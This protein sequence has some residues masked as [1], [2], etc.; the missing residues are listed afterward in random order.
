V[1][2]DDDTA[3]PIDEQLTS[4][5]G[6]IDDDWHVTTVEPLDCCQDCGDYANEHEPPI[7]DGG[8]PRDDEIAQ[9]YDYR[10]L[11]DGQIVRFVKEDS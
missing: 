2:P 1:T 4:W 10:V 5:N 7:V 11:C 3:R 6:G 9:I 8:V